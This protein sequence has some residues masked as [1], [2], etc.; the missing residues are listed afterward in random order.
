MASLPVSG[1]S[2]LEID[3]VTYIAKYDNTWTQ[4]GV[5]TSKFINCDK[6]A[7]EWSAC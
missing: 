2:K 1:F 3:D 4:F 7:I 5:E 6:F